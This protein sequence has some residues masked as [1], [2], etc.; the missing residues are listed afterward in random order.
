MA[1]SP[2]GITW[3]KHDDPATADPLYAE[4]DPVFRISA[5]EKAFDSWRLTD[6]GVQKTAD[7][8][9]MVY[10]GSSFNTPGA[11]GMA[12]SQDGI[13]WRRTS[14]Q[15]LLSQADSGKLGIDFIS[16]LRHGDKDL[17]YIEAGGTAGTSI[18]L[19]SRSHLF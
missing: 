9:A 6:T 11:L 15:P 18:Y 5:D 3:T 13:T 2:D 1:T 12:V 8:W 10:R 16:Y 17:V 19:A 4:S 7:G 14:D